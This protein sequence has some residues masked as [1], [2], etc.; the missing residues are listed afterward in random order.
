MLGT[1]P[2]V[3][4]G[5]RQIPE[6]VEIIQQWKHCQHELDNYCRSLDAHCATYRNTIEL[7][8]EG[9]VNLQDDVDV[10][11]DNPEG[12][13]DQY[14]E[15][16]KLRLGRSYHVYWRILENMKEALHTAQREFGINE[17]GEVCCWRLIKILLAKSVI[18]RPIGTQRI[19]SKGFTKG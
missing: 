1:F 9:I 6:G 19:F 11:I 10:A 18:R 15:Q 14:E 5:L 13:L 2:V 17:R 16:L 4:K 7:L 12:V 8:L 3:V